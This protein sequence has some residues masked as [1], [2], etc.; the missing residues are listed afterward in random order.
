[1]LLMRSLSSAGTGSD[2]YAQRRS[3]PIVSPSCTSTTPAAAL[4]LMRSEGSTT[5]TGG[6]AG[7]SR[8]T[9][10]AAGNGDNAAAHDNVNETRPEL[11]WRREGTH[12]VHRFALIRVMETG[13]AALRLSGSAK[14]IAPRAMAPNGPPLCP[15][16]EALGLLVCCRRAGLRCPAPAAR[17]SGEL[18]VSGLKRRLR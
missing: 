13:D 6:P 17:T 8:A 11:A 18:P 9:C 10:A 2:R 3:L 1:M 7:A 5:S 15:A 16:G 12:D 4:P 14:I